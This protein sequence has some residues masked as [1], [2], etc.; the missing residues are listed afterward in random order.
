M[1]N[2]YS[3][4]TSFSRASLAL[5]VITA[6][7]ACGSSDEANSASGDGGAGVVCH[8]AALWSGLNDARRSRTATFGLCTVSFHTSD[9]VVHATS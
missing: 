5:L 7:A 4:L 1:Q 6:G 9:D 2:N 8:A 3:S